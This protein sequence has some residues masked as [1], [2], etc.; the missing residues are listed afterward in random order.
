M[1]TSS[2]RSLL[3]TPKARQQGFS[4]VIVMIILVIVSMLGVAASQMVLMA[5][6]SSRYDRDW[7]IAFQGAEAALMDAEFDMRG[8][9]TSAAKRVDTFSP[10]SLLGFAAGCGSGGDLGLCLPST[11]G[12]PVWYDV[13]FTDATTAAKTVRL[14]DF[15]DRTFATGTAGVQPALRPRYIIEAIP[16]LSPGTSSTGAP[17]T[18]FRVTA[19]GF[20]PRTDTQAVVQMVFRKE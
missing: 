10:T 7:Q 15:T 14:G 11:T 17:K 8:P 4:L 9:N 19:M 5:E 12:R 13:D 6:R 3:R 1:N 20:G 16:D 2:L 18:L